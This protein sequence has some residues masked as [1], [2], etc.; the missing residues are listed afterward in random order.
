MQ[1][2][3]SHVFRRRTGFNQP[4]NDVHTALVT[5]SNGRKKESKAWHESFPWN[6]IV[7]RPRSNRWYTPLPT[8]YVRETWTHAFR[9]VDVLRVP[10]RGTPT[11]KGARGTSQ[12]GRA[13]LLARFLVPGSRFLYPRMQ[14]SQGNPLPRSWLATIQLRRNDFAWQQLPREDGRE[15]EER[16]EEKIH[17]ESELTRDKRDSC[18]KFA[19]DRY[20]FIALSSR[21]YLASLTIG[22]SAP[23]E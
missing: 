23:R 16:N 12:A 2:S 10:A 6:N 4:D 18:L 7:H 8:D 9:P 15:V 13:L 21:G 1:S 5:A 14:N 11:W 22:R 20:R 17:V 3:A 19:H